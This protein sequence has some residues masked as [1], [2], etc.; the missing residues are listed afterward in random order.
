MLTDTAWCELMSV[1]ASWY[2]DC[3]SET[4]LHGLLWRRYFAVV[5]PL[6]VTVTGAVDGTAGPTYPH[7]STIAVTAQLP[8][9]TNSACHTQ[10]LSGHGMQDE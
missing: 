3:R 10:N 7:G 5:R 6:L 2:L 8:A 4:R 1:D 9:L